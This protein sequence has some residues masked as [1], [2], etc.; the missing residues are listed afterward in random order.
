MEPVPAVAMTTVP[1]MK[2]TGETRLTAGLAGHYVVPVVLVAGDVAVCEEAKK[3]LPWVE[4]VAVKDKGI[5][6]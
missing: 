4:T 2:A 5:Y 1:T 3:L 6:Q